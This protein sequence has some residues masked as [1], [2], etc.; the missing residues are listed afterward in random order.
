MT[1]I[2]YIY[3]KYVYI[4]YI[5]HHCVSMDHNLKNSGLKYK[6]TKTDIVQEA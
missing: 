4:I 1:S 3:T 2:Q 6:Y 5:P